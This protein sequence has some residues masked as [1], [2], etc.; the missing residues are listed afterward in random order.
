MSPDDNVTNGVW[1]RCSIRTLRARRAVITQEPRSEDGQ[2]R[3]R[4]QGGSQAGARHSPPSA[5]L[6]R[7]LNRWDRY[8]VTEQYFNGSLSDHSEVTTAAVACSGY[9]VTCCLNP[10]SQG[11][12]KT[13]DFSSFDRLQSRISRYF[14]ALQH[15]LLPHVF[16]HL[17]IHFIFISQYTWYS[18]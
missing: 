6:P 7:H 8:Y 16:V 13:V 2:D 5:G 17:K 1:G 18:V 11:M 4:H 3:G 14:T 15:I 9:T 12:F 10:L